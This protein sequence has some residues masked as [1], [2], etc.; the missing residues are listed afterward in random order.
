MDATAKTSMKEL[1]S[2]Y[3]ST[4]Q[5][6]MSQFDWTAVE[7]CADWLYECHQKDQ[8]VFI[9]GNGG[10]AGNAV[11]LAND[12]LFGVAPKGAALQVEALSA[13]TSVLTCLGNDI[14]YDKIYSHQLRTKGKPGDVLIVLSGS[15][16]SPNILAALDVARELGMKSVAILGY[17]GGKAKL[18][19]DLPL[20]F[21]VDDMQISEDMQLIVG[22]MLMRELH[23]RL[24]A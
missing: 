1:I 6:T 8:K 3:I 18:L 2:D 15:G 5:G 11:H 22:H 24:A 13:N 17:K 20:H 21:A 12:F 16:N 19:A 10:S 4:L 9:C 23:N 14:G 7:Q